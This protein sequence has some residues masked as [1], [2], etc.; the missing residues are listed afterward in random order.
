[1]N[2]WIAHYFSSAINFINLIKEYNNNIKI[3]CT[4]K[5]D[6]SLLLKEADY[7]EIEPILNDEEYI[8]YCLEFCIRNNIKIFF[9]NYLKIPIISKN[10]YLFENINVKV[11]VDSNYELISSLD[12]KEKTYKLFNDKITEIIPEYYIV[13]NYKDFEKAYSNL[14]SKYKQVCFKPVE[15]VGGKGFRIIDEWANSISSLLCEFHPRISYK[16]VID[17]LKTKEKFTDLIVMEYLSGFEYSVDCF[18]DG[19][20][21]LVSIP[22]KKL[23][24]KLRYIENN[25]EI[26]EICKNIYSF[27]K[28]EYA[29]NIQFR[30]SKDNIPKLLEINP[31]L[32]GGSHLSCKSGINLLELCIKKALGE[33]LNI[34]N[35]KFDILVYDN[36]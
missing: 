31:R 30:F 8:N 28:V 23:N 16:Q 17:I 4:N 15:S 14:I 9:P 12:N 21:V 20:N 13:N 5:N 22:R 11:I 25:K 33:E 10:K 32:S 26:I 18:G 19:E 3:Y 7:S 27:I 36:F 1:M 2:I 24:G 35:P 6:Y 34:I 29:F